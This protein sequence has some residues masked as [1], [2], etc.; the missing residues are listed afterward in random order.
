MTVRS[1]VSMVVGVAAAATFSVAGNAKGMDTTEVVATVAF[2][3]YVGETSFPAGSYT[4]S[5]ANI[6][7]ESVMLRP[8]AG[9]DVT[10]VA[11]ITRLAQRG[12][13]A[14]T[15]D[16]NLVF[17]KVGDRSVLS[18][19]WIPGRDGYLVRGTAEAHKEALVNSV[20]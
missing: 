8:S 14:R 11:V 18:E 4:I 7:A 19:V 9:K 1:F 15:T 6:G 13:S 20:K 3:F 5:A 10:T 2:E 16:S 12:R 17:D